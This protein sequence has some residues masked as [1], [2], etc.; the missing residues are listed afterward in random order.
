MSAN[1]YTA[2]K[3]DTA[4]T[5]TAWTKDPLT[6][7]TAVAPA[8]LTGTVWANNYATPGAGASTNN[9]ITRNVNNGNSFAIAID[10]NL[11]A[12]TW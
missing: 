6:G 3:V 11:G 12:V 4:T 10:H 1:G 8:A 2:F 9:K 5:A 7:G